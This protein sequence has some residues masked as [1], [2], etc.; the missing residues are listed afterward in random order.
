[1]TFLIILILI[2]VIGPS[3]IRLLFPF[4]LKSFIKR[5]QKQMNQQFQQQNN[6]NSREGEINIKKPTT[7][8]EKAAHKD[9]LGEY[10]DFEEIKE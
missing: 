5:A 8:K 2:F 1:L 6:S 7:S 9:E 10:V 4:L 3:L